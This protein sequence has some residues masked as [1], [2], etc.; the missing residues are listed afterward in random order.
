MLMDD[1]KLRWVETCLEIGD[2]CESGFYFLKNFIIGDEF[3]MFEYGFKT[4]RPS[5]KWHPQRSLATRRPEW[6][7]QRWKAWILCY[8]T[9]F[10][11]HEFIWC[12]YGTTVN[13][14]FFVEV[15]KKLKSMVHRVVS[16][17]V[18]DWKLH[19]DNASAYIVFLRD[20]YSGWFKG[21]SGS[22][23]ILQSWCNFIKLWQSQ[24]GLHLGFKGYFGGGLLR[25]FD[26]SMEAMYRCRR[27]L[28]SSHLMRCTGS[29]H[30]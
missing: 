20:P 13:V 21:I 27:S 12:Y 29:I 24:G 15:L 2:L 1:Q 16:D 10:V 11:H 14:K 6:R 9:S 18:D 30:F 26:I 3:W 19:Y 25:G 17:I 4:N 7:S 8:L 23:A 28:F 22:P 5:I